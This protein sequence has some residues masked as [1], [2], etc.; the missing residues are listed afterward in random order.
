MTTDLKH[1]A[2]C[3]SHRLLGDTFH[4]CTL[5]PDCAPPASDGDFDADSWRD[6]DVRMAAYVGTACEV[7]RRMG[8]LCGPHGHL[9]SP[10]H[11]RR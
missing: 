4:L 8:A 11:G 2:T 7:M 10:A 3:Q 5:P 6:S 1:C 9:W